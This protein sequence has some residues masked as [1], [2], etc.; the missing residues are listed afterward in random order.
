[1]KR[2]FLGYAALVASLVGTASAEYGLALAVGFGPWLA[3]CVP[4][5]LDIYALRAF[6]SKRDVPAV[7]AALIAVNACAHLV[8]AGLLPVCI[9]LVVGV[10]AIAPLVLYRVHALTAHSAPRN[11][12]A[13]DVPTTAPAPEPAP[14]ERPVVP[15]PVTAARQP[16]RSAPAHPAIASDDADELLAEARALAARLGRTPPLRMLQA[17]LSIGQRRAQRL[18]AT[19]AA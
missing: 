16:A 8:A 17:E 15:T 1:M 3:A 14:A 13:A 5:A 7:V 19:L 6:A 18:Q 4:A 12:P 10:S 11:A 2:D 9:P